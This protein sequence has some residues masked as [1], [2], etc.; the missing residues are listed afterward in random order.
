[1]NETVVPYDNEGW[2]IVGYFDLQR[3]GQYGVGGGWQVICSHGI[4]NM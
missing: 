3:F 2:S 1:M 4:I